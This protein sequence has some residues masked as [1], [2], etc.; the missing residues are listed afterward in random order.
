M[1][2]CLPQARDPT[3]KFRT[4]RMS[5]L[6]ISRHPII[7]AC[8]GRF[9]FEFEIGTFP[10][11]D[12]HRSHQPE[13]RKESSGCSRA[14]PRTTTCKP[15]LRLSIA[16]RAYLI[17]WQARLSSVSASRKPPHNCHHRR[18]SLSISMSLRVNISR[19]RLAKL[20]WWACCCCVAISH[21]VLAASG[22]HGSS[23]TP[24]P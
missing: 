5:V 13:A 23:G 21:D 24:C 20:L 19:L 7:S 22:G 17:S 9:E 3:H 1:R 14:P 18:H 10:C 8:T 12:R 2:W 11:R 6:C 4:N 15:W 16:T